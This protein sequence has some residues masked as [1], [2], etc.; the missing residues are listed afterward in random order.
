MDFRKG[1]KWAGVDSI[2]SGMAL[3]QARPDDGLICSSC[4]GT[5]KV[6]CFNCRGKG[7]LPA[8][9]RSVPC[10]ICKGEKLWYC[11]DCQATGMIRRK[12]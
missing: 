12:R 4:T 7:E 2:K 11:A 10:Y 3:R 6:P 8:G 1:S 5:G 9:N